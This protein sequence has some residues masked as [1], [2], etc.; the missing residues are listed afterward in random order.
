MTWVE[1][2]PGVWHRRRGGLVL[3]LVALPEGAVGWVLRGGVV[4]GPLRLP[5]PAV[6][7]GGTPVAPAAPG[8]YPRPPG[9]G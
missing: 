7:S 3:E 2:K 9:P 6:R 8:G 5:A 4:L 1:V